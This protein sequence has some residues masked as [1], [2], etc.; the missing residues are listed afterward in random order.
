[1]AIS[2]PKITTMYTLKSK[3]KFIF[4][5]FICFNSFLP[6]S[7]AIAPEP[8]IPTV[9]FTSSPGSCNEIDLSFIPGDGSR[10]LVIGC[11]GSP[12]SV[13]P[14]DGTSYS[15]GS[16]YGTGSFLG[17]GNYVVYNGSGTGTV[18]TGLDGGSQ[19]YFAIFEYNG[20]GTNANYLISG[21]LETD[22]IATG[23]SLTVLSSTGDICF[24]DSVTLEA[25]GAT[26]Y[27]WSPATGLSSVT[28]SIVTANPSITTLYSVTGT[29][30][31]GC[32][33]QKTLNIIVNQLPNVT[34]ST[35]SNVC[36]NAGLV[37]LNGGV[38]IGGIYSGLGISSN[39]LNPT[40]AGAGTHTVTYVYTDAHGCTD[41][42]STPITILNSP[43]V[44]FATI[45]SVC[46]GHSPVVLS[47]GSPTGGTYFGTGMT[48]GTTFN[49]S[50]SG[51][52][53]FQL[54]Y[55]Y[56]SSG[57]SD[58][59]V[60]SITVNPLPIVSFATLTPVCLNTI[61]FGLT[62]GSPAGGNYTGAGVS[63]N[64]FDPL[65]SDTGIH[66]LTYTFT[67]SNGCVS[68]DTSAMT[69]NMFPEVTL[70]PISAVCLNTGPVALSGGLPAGGTFSGTAI[71]GTTFFTGIAGAGAHIVTYS[72]TDDNQCVNTAN[73][74]LTVNPIPSLS[75][76]ADTTICSD[77][78]IVLTA[79]TAYY[80]YL[81]SNGANTPAITFDSTGYGLG[82]F[83]I[84]LRVTNSFGCAN[85]DT[86]FVTVD[87]CSGISGVGE[88]TS[89][90]FPNP[91]HSALTITC[92][93]EFSAK[94]YDPSGR[95][96]EFIPSAFGKAEVAADLPQ[97]MYLLIMKTK[98]GM[99]REVI[100][101][102]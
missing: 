29:D 22:A 98:N 49:P 16:L 70:N 56:S 20:V 86:L 64:T 26:S 30:T 74:T 3:K 32:Q 73:Q 10:R 44:S 77:A 54:S 59:A 27:T 62:S 19:Y 99:R 91:F 51:L 68:S 2:S 76:G 100:L 78:S 92:D 21:Y 39:D 42:T 48:G 9:S 45:P 71:G 5:L 69:V 17:D 47:Q 96:L 8:T 80:S 15:A 75:L 83:R 79:G 28:D 63:S 72:F 52:G 6:S 24:G 55:V 33:D 14:I 57:C 97:G 65:V 67:D 7:K 34:I 102:Q 40:I 12:V 89:A 35:Q 41:S 23:I 36:I 13:F 101:K 25:H 90:I 11:S 38:P 1:M 53:T 37:H 61:A 85:R 31:S 95:L 46:T 84:T 18:I 43:S 88:F 81:W 66:L 60:S 93:Q 94:V 50:V 58:T 4:L 82:A 87:P